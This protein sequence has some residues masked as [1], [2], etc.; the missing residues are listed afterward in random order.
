MHLPG[1]RIY[2]VVAWHA[3]TGP[4]PPLSRLDPRLPAPPVAQSVA[5]APPS[6]TGHPIRRRHDRGASS[7]RRWNA[8][9]SRGRHIARVW[10]S[11]PW[12]W[13]PPPPAGGLGLPPAAS[14]PF[15]G[16]RLPPPPA[17]PLLPLLRR[18]CFPAT[19]APPRLCSCFGLGLLLLDAGL[20]RQRPHQTPSLARLPL[21]RCQGRTRRISRRWL[22][23]LRWPL[24]G[25][26]APPRRQCPPRAAPRGLP[27]RP[28]GRYSHG[29]RPPAFLCAL[30]APPS[31]RWP[32]NC[33]R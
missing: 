1:A 27:A 11:T 2:V 4:R 19:P 30:R 23:L 28:A 17:G 33:P 8:P 10:S 16:R 21:R 18:S 31:S 9:P 32:P 7:H 25:V 3:A 15:S 22:L 14:I 6:A 26:C 20:R 12:A 24:R 29:Q 13:P 5:S